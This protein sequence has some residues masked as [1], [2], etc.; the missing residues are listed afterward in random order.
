MW[1]ENVFDNVQYSASFGFLPLKLK[2]C[3][4]HFMSQQ[5]GKEQA[6]SVRGPWPYR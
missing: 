6:A 1:R 4:R 5:E 3:F 2:S